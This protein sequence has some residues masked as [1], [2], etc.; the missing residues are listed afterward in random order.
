MY[1]NDFI[2]LLFIGCGPLLIFLF[3]KR[4]LSPILKCCSLHFGRLCWSFHFFLVFLITLCY[5]LLH[6]E[7]IFP[8]G[9]AFPIMFCSH[10]SFHQCFIWCMSCS[11]VWCRSITHQHILYHKKACLTI[12]V[13]YLFSFVKQFHK[14]FCL[15]I[16]SLV[17]WC[18]SVVVESH[19][20]GK[21][22][23]FY[24]LE[25]RPVISFQ[26]FRYSMCCKYFPQPV[27]S[28]SE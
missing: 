2:I 22:C 13:C 7:I 1:F 20:C 18:Y 21:F 17:F 4:I 11:W 9:E 28:N 27:T 25:W 16:G 24:I 23:E 19:F 15:Y 14:A 8:L 12:T 3:F 5:F 6:V 26:S 10:I